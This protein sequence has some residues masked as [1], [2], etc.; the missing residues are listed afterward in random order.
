M[1]RGGGVGGVARREGKGVGGLG[2]GWGGVGVWMR[3]GVG[4]EGGRVLKR[5]LMGFFPRERRFFLGISF[6]DFFFW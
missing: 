6:K 5:V 3:G 2:M 4:F 1:G